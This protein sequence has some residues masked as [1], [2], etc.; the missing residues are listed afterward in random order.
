MSTDAENEMQMQMQMQNE[1]GGEQ[2]QSLSEEHSEIDLYSFHEQAAGRLAI[3]PAEAKIEF[4]D[5]V[6]S[7][8]KL[9]PDETKVLWPQSTDSPDD[10]QNWSDRRKLL[11]LVIVTL[12]AIVPNFDSGIGIDGIFPRRPI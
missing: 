12:A 5:A 3:D 11:L 10:P 6:A 2:E 7:R 4:G 1:K 9:S 8:L